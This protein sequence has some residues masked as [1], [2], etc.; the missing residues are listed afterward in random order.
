M[1]LYDYDSPVSITRDIYWVGFYDEQASLHCNPYL[2]IDE[3]EAILFD[4]GSIPHFPI[5]MRKVIDLVRPE[6]IRYIVASH[7]DPD[8]CGNLP[9]LEDVIGP[10]SLKILAHMNTI[11]LIRHYG[12]RS[13]LVAVDRMDYRLSLA[14]GRILDFIFTP[15]LHSPGAIATFDR[16][17]R[18][19][20]TSDIFGAISTENWSLFAR[21]DFLTPMTV[22]HQTYMSSGRALA[23]CMARFAALEPMRILPQHGSVLEGEQI[24][25]AMD[26]LRS[27]PCGSDLP[28]G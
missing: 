11:R 13:E 4:P 28:R 3:D 10:G 7:Q 25:Q 9:V 2:M 27:L 24:Q 14:S 6:T 20:F 12:V 1:P 26:Y 21:G 22:W 18:S 19:L 23:D 17:T 16:K 15:F 8:V 5:V